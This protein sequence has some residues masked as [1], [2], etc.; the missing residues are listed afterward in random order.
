MA[1]AFLRHY[2]GDRFDSQSVGTT[3]KSVNPLTIK[4]V[5]E[6]G[7]SMEGHRSKSIG[8]FLGRQSVRHAIF[9][10]S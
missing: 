8:E 1:E 2:A 7:V 10:C 3:P 9:V 5:E 4:V 6:I